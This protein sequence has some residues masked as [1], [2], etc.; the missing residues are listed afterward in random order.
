MICM[1]CMIGPLHDANIGFVEFHT[2]RDLLCDLHTLPLMAAPFH[3]MHGLYRLSHSEYPRTPDDRINSFVNRLGSS[4]THSRGLSR[5][6]D[7]GKVLNGAALAAGHVFYD[8]YLAQRSTGPAPEP[9]TPGPLLTVINSIQC[10]GELGVAAARQLPFGHKLMSLAGTFHPPGTILTPA[11]MMYT[12]QHALTFPRR[13]DHG[14][15]LT[16]LD[17]T[18]ANV[19]KYIR[20][21]HNITDVNVCFEWC[22]YIPMVKTFTI[23]P[24][25]TELLYYKVCRSWLRL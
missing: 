17:D 5:A 18:T 22:G 6:L 2:N 1:I 11:E 12:Q 23:I 24:T 10:A 20:S 7:R 9:F 21:T 14:H 13:S 15:M 4:I 19:C 25:G 3:C 16:Q 8:V